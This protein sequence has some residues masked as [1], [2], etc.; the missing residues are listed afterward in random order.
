VRWLLSHRAG[1]PIIDAPL[2]LEDVCAWEPVIRALEIQK[3]LWDPGVFC[4]YHP[5]TWGFLVGELVRRITDRSLGTFFAEEI[6]R[7]LGVSAWIG[8]P[9]EEES[10]VVHLELEPPP[11][12]FAPLLEHLGPDSVSARFYSLGG[13]FAESTV[14]DDGGFNRRILRAA[15]LP[16]SNLVT[17]ARSLARIYAATVGDVDGVRLLEPSTV[18]SMCVLQTQ[19][20]PPFQTLPESAASTLTALGFDMEMAMALGFER[21]MEV[22][23]LL[24][25]RSFGHFGAGGSLGAADPETEVGFSY[26]MNHMAGGVDHRASDLLAAVAKCA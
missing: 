13:A 21:P 16:S 19:G 3:P 24:S 17:D 15:E 22:R 20:V 18:E 23:P 10:R 6:A 8:L 25:P 14:T 4:A 26:V 7:P 1:L 9:E 12:E 5:R 11:P 2:T